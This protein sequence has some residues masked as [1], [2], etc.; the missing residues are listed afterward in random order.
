[1]S[2]VN[3]E[4]IATWGAAILTVNHLLDSILVIFT[5]V[6]DASVSLAKTVAACAV[7]KAAAG[8]QNSLVDRPLAVVAGDGKI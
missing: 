6:D 2:N 4:C 5:E 1:M 8:A 3:A 7:E